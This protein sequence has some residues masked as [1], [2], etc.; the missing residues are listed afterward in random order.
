[1]L[2]QQGG[3]IVLQ[4]FDWNGGLFHDMIQNFK[5]VFKWNWQ[6]GFSDV[7]T[8]IC[9]S[10][11]CIAT[12]FV[13]IAGKNIIIKI[14]A[15]VNIF[16]WLIYYFSVRIN[17]YAYGSFGNRYHLFF[18]PMWII[19]YFAVGINLYQM[20]ADRLYKKKSA[21]QICCAMI[22]FCLIFGF[23]FF[24]WNKSIK[25]NWDK[26]NIRG[27]V[28]AWYAQNAEMSNTI[29]YYAADSGFSYYVKTN[30]RYTEQTENNVIY[31]PW[32]RYKNQ[33]QEAYIDYVKSVYQDSLPD[34][35]YIIGSQISDD[36]DVLV[37]AIISEGYS[38]EDLFSSNDAYLVRLT[39]TVE[40]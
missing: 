22:G 11:I 26:Q 37:S 10:V 39:K 31:T 29:V 19:L 27:A 30:D 16:T 15:V 18:I 25:Y 6:S 34:E 20:M 8:N 35:I 23:S 7:A 9:I 12:L 21:F 38:R 33:R 28:E 4:V 2:N 1:M 17:L 24:S 40:E 13:L 36:F 14:F 32:H 3:K 5:T